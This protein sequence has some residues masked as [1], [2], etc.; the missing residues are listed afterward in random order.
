MKNKKTMVSVIVFVMSV[1]G[2]LFAEDAPQKKQAPTPAATTEK[3]PVVKTK[4][5][6]LDGEVISVDATAKQI[7]VKREKGNAT[8]DVTDKTNIT[9][10]K[11]DITLSEIVAGD[12][13]LV[14]FKKEGDKR[15][16]TT[17]KVKVPKTASNAE[18]KE[19]KPAENK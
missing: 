11:K 4:T 19:A 14:A 18:K 1:G 2:L 5:L 17:I 8:L 3:A 12:K 13:V 6:L 9:K 16:A 10:G 15:R 7:V